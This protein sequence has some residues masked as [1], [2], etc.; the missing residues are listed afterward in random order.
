MLNTQPNDMESSPAD[1]LLMSRLYG[2]SPFISGAFEGI[3]QS[4]KDII[5]RFHREQ[6]IKL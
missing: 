1:A 2:A 6:F 4:G 5:A 3:F